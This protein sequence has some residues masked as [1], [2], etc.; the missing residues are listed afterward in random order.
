MTP[1]RLRL[2]VA[3]GCVLLGILPG[4]A[5][6]ALPPSPSSA[7]LAI[8]AQYRDRHVQGMRSGDASLLSAAA[9]A[10]NV[11]L[12]PVSQPT[13]FGSANAAAYYQAFLA[14]F[15]VDACTRTSAGQFDLGTRVVEIGRYTQKLTRK[16]T[17]EAFELTGKYLDAWEKRP[18]GTL[19]LVTA[20][21]N[22]DTWQPA[23]EAMRFSEV[24]SVRTAFEPR[25]P[26]HSEVSFELAALGLLHEAAVVQHDARLWAR[27]YSDDAILLANNGGLH[28]GRQAVDA[29]IATHA[30]ELPVF[31]KLDLRIDRIE[32]LG[33]YVFE[34]ASQVANWRRGDASG[35]STGKNLRIWRREPG[36][37]SLKIILAIGAYDQ[38]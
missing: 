2:S 23:A 26:I 12:M 24:P 16:S 29:Y 22:H 35:V 31:E 25:A 30:P 21:W 7:D 14:R 33:D 20:A 18:D 36:G 4:G 10:E 34:Y 11:R 19:Q 9:V 13:V 32:E 38:G 5:F 28:A 27:L 15:A 3:A 6:A 17:G 8:L 37:H 1:F